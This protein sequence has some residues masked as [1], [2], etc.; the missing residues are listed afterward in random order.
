M[1]YILVAILWSWVCLLSSCNKE[2]QKENI[3]STFVLSDTMMKRIKLDTVKDDIVKSQLLLMGKIYPDENKVIEV[4]P[5]VGGNV[6]DV[7]VELGDFVKK[8]EILAV[9]KSGEIADYERQLI[10][11]RSD[12]LVAEKQ[13]SVAQDLYESKL[14]SERDVVSAKKEVEKA[15]A[16]LNRINE[17]YKIYNIGTESDYVI[18][19]PISGFVVDKNINR[20]M[21]IR[22]DKTDHVFTISQLDELWVIANVFE[23]DISK[24]KIGYEAE[25]HTIS[26]PDKNFRG[27]IDKIYN[28]LD[29]E[30]KTMQIR[31]KINNDESLLKPEMHATIKLSYKENYALSSVPAASVIFDKSKNFVMVFKDKYNIE[32]REVEVAKSLGKVTYLSKGVAAGEIVISQNQL[33]I[34]DALND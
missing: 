18:K 6:K 29:P 4:Y 33:L 27:K 17:I 19:A 11:A 12:L 1:K 28:V 10:D 3:K 30:T 31:I 24:V 21:Q 25:V 20:D 26:Y 9:I 7:F 15:Q 2:V 32:T 23:S 22:S 5:L 8:G 13:Y 14:T 34:Y 16:S